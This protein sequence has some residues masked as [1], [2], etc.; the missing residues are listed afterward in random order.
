MKHSLSIL[1]L[2][3]AAT[4]LAHAAGP[5]VGQPAPDFTLP[6]AKGDSHA[7]SD[8]K[9]KIVVL[10]WFNDGCPFVKK[11][12]GSGSMQ[13]LQEQARK[14]GVVWLTIVSSAP[15]KQGY[16]EP[17]QALAEKKKLGMRSKALLLDPEGK[18]GRM[19]EA[20]TTPDM[21]VINADGVLVYKGAIDDQPTPDPATLKGATNYVANALAALEAGQPV[22]PA[23]TKSYGCS[24]KY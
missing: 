20:R 3:L 8:Y 18:V 14:D 9:G 12:Y 15:G 1:V 17:E 23:E 6:D 13:R 19:Y 7:L 21:F 5:L 22:N 11:H 10:E 4:V 16:L 2:A 24:V